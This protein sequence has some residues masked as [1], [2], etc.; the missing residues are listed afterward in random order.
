MLFTPSYDKSCK[1]YQTRVTECLASIVSA[2][3][4]LPR[5]IYISAEGTGGAGKH[6][7]RHPRRCEYLVISLHPVIFVLGLN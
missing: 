5:S 6:R 2:L 4:A 7:Q 1:L 3:S